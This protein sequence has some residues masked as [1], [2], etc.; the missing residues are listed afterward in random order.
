[1]QESFLRQTPGSTKCREELDLLQEDSEQTSFPQPPTQLA[2]CG[3]D[4]VS[5]THVLKEVDIISLFPG[6]QGANLY[7]S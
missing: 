6:R 2:F 5:D 7:H 4:S 3:P 1:M